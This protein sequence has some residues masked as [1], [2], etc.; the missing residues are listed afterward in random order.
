M[1]YVNIYICIVKKQGTELDQ[2]KKKLVNE[3]PTHYSDFANRY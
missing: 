2:K 1:Y 3:L